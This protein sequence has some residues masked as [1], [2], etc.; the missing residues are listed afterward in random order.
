MQG[1][2]QQ[3]PRDLKLLREIQISTAVLS[4]IKFPPTGQQVQLSTLVK[5]TMAAHH[6]WLHGPSLST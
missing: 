4:Y 2:A 5:W 6:V 1:D 3:L